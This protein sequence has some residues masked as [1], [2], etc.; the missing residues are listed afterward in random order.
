ME[1]KGNLICEFKSIKNH[2]ICFKIL[3]FSH[4]SF[5]GFY[6]Q[7]CCWML[8]LLPLMGWYRCMFE[9]LSLFC[10]DLFCLVCMN[11]IEL[12]CSIYPKLFI[13]SIHF[14]KFSFI[15][16]TISI[17]YTYLL[18]T[19]YAVWSHFRYFCII[20]SWWF[21]GEVGRKRSRMDD[22]MCKNELIFWMLE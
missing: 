20:K 12:S 19:S 4:Y 10:L 2:D 8:L 6:A 14:I 13:I 3:F 7:C 17:S 9:Y 15:Q 16:F 21:L 11:R 22:G 18:Y 5:F 1:N